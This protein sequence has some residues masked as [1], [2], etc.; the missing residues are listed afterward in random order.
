MGMFWMP[1]ERR[2]CLVERQGSLRQCCGPP[3]N[4]TER[5]GSTDKHELQK[6]HFP[7]GFCSQTWQ[8]SQP[9]GVFL[10]PWPVRGILSRWRWTGRWGRRLGKERW[11]IPR[12]TSA[13]LPLLPSHAS[14]GCRDRTLWSVFVVQR[15]DKLVIG[16]VTRCHVSVGK[17][18]QGSR[19]PW[20]KCVGRSSS[21]HCF[22]SKHL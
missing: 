12:Y 18:T 1:D 20:Q 22:S 8:H 3:A 16:N 14:R 9:V 7:P 10:P 2:C 6:G 4:A 11:L 21:D 5:G 19:D 17:A 13:P 15:G